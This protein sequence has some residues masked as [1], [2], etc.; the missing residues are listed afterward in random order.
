MH[1]LEKAR[2][3][4]SGRASE[5]ESERKRESGKAFQGWREERRTPSNATRPTTVYI[6]VH[7]IALPLCPRIPVRTLTKPL[8]IAR[9]L[10]HIIRE[11]Q[12]EEWISSAR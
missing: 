3:R 7:S 5:R 9:V 10:S 4:A 6:L 12:P 2:A 11:S 8:S 1:L